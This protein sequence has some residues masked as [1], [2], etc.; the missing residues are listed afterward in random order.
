VRVCTNISCLLRGADGIMESL[1]K[2][3]GVEAGETTTD[4]RFTVF[5][6]ECLG[7]CG[8][9]PMMAVGDDYHEDLKAD[10][11]DEILERYR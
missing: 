3:L 11:L 4:G 9:A 8:G 10:Q 5:A 7:A 1:C 2:S 6:A